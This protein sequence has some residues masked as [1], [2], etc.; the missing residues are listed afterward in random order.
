MNDDL[1]VSW[2]LVG[3][4]IGGQPANVLG[5]HIYDMTDLSAPVQVADE[6]GGTTHTLVGF[7]TDPTAIYPVAVAAYNAIGEGPMSTIVIPSPPSAS[8]PGQVTGVTATIV[9]K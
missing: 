3:L 1:L 7:V 8:V 2:N 5:Y 4:D 6:T 9:P